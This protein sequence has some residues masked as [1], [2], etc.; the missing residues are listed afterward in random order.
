MSG[1]LILPDELIVNVLKYADYKTVIACR[2]SCR[3]LKEIVATCSAIQY[4]VELAA[5]GMSDGILN[6][7]VPVE[8]LRRLRDAQMAWKSPVWSSV[9]HFPYSR[10]MSPY[11]M[12]TSGNLVVFRSSRSRIGELVLLRFPSESRGI[13]ERQWNLDLGSNRLETFSVDDSQDLVVFSCL[14]AIHI[15]TLSTG[16]V[17]PSTSTAGS[18]RSPSILGGFNLHIHGDLLLM[19]GNSS[20][21]SG[22]VWDW[23]TGEHIARIASPPPP[24]SGIVAFRSSVTALPDAHGDVHCPTFHFMLELPIA[25]PPYFTD[26]HANTLPTDWAGSGHPGCFHAD[27]DRRL[28]I[29]ELGSAAADGLALAFTQHTLYVPHDVFLSY[30]AAHAQAQP[31]AGHPT[32]ATV[33]PS[34]PGPGTEPAV[35]VVPWRAWSPDH[36]RLTK[37]PNV[38]QRNLGLHKACG[39]HALSEPHVLP[40]RRILRVA[41]Y[42]PYRVARSRLADADAD[43]GA[44]GCGEDDEDRDE[45]EDDAAGERCPRRPRRSDRAPGALPLPP[46]GMPIPYVEKDIRLPDGLRSEHVRCVLGEDVVALFEFSVGGHDGPAHKI[47]KIHYHPI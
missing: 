5:A 18:I 22:L 26:L 37:V 23:K 44:G 1:I 17:H 14:S 8:R 9:D 38:S 34:G 35:V 12:M 19:L 32:T 29:L 16:C 13:P 24:T 6:G 42:H 36:T 33:L 39:M 4:I 41:D 31:G 11:P 47:V 27:P 28:L 46:R 45:D 43:A 30:I 25:I 10:G 21:L 3:H 15:R 40:D 2:R 20:G 7:V